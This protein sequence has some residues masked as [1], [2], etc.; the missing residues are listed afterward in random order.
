MNNEEKL[1]AELPKFSE[2][3]ISGV[4]LFIRNTFS[5]FAVGDEITC[6]SNKCHNRKCHCQEV[7]Y[8][9]LI[10]NG[11]SKLYMKWICEVYCL[12]PERSDNDMD[13]EAGINFGDNLDE[14]LQCTCGNMQNN[15]DGSSDGSNGIDVDA[16][17][18]H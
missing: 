2:G 3:Y 15:E 14:M 7:V 5:R 9:H 4:K 12:D 8:N 10:W 13:C 18:F 1:W 16:R 6:P 11:P 17:K